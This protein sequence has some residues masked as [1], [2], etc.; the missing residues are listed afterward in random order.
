M[1]INVVVDQ[2]TASDWSDMA[3]AFD[4]YNI[5][6]TWSF[7]KQR[8]AEMKGRVSRLL[9]LRA[10]KT[11]G[12]AQVRIK[13]IPGLRSGIAYAYWGPLWR[14][15]G[16]DSAD[17]RMVL[18]AIRQ[19]YVRRRGFVVRIVPNVTEE[20]ASEQIVAAFDD[21]G[22]LHDSTTARYRTFVLDLTP[23][24]DE[25]RRALA[26]KWRNCL[27]QAER[28]HLEIRSGTGRELVAEFARLYEEMASRKGFRSN[29]SARSFALVQ[30]GLP[31]REKQTVLLTYLGGQALA[32]H[33]S[34]TLG[35]TCVYLMGASNEPGRRLKASYLLQW[36]AVRRAKEAGARRYDLGG[37]DPVG[38]PGVHRFKAGLSGCDCCFIGQYQ[39]SRGG[40]SNRMVPIAEHVYRSLANSRLLS[41][42]Y[43][44]AGLNGGGGRRAG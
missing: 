35:G 17:L 30:D 10:G 5:Y 38:N 32:G 11:I 28:Q 26:Q 20:D 13:R 37:I 29:V 8:A 34:S 25:L 44:A 3:S 36:H 39:A 31:Q 27:N 18:D 6:Q 1:S 2:V 22:F 40:L 12:M 33:V 9:V 4:D 15:P 41:W 21:A 14:R 7:A 23:P 43:R 24:L 19:E 16:S 42:M